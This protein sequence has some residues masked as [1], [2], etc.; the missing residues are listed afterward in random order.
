[1][2]IQRSWYL[3]MVLFGT[4]AVIY[5]LFFADLSAEA[6]TLNVVI[7]ALFYAFV[8]FSNKRGS[9]SD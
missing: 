4:A 7:Y 3:A 1:M 2:R 6:R 8:V 5:G 9:A